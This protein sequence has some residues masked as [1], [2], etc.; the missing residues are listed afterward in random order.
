MCHL[1]CV[2]FH[3]CHSHRP[4]SCIPPLCSEPKNGFNLFEKRGF[5][6][7]KYYHT[8]FDQKSP[9][10]WVPVIAKWKKQTTEQ[11]DIENYRLN[12][13]GGQ[14]SEHVITAW[15]WAANRNLLQTG[16]ATFVKNLLLT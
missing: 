6:I 11:T 1:F 2:I 14:F 16:S 7:F 12:C 8:L 15:Q 3:Q 9:T 4:S 10:L 5:F 13:P